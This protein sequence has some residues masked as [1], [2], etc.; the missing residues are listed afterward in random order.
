[1]NKSVMIKFLS[2]LLLHLDNSGWEPLTPVNIGD[3]VKQM[4]VTIC[5][6]RSGPRKKIVGTSIDVPQRVS[7]C[8]VEI[9]D[10]QIIFYTVPATV[11]AD[12]IITSSSDLAGVSSGVVSIISDYITLQLPI[13]S[14]PSVFLQFRPRH[15]TR[16]NSSL[17]S[18]IIG[19]FSNAGYN[20]SIV[21]SLNHNDSVFFFILS[22]S[23]SGEVRQLTRQVAGLGLKDS[24][25]PFQPIV[26]RRKSSF[27]RSFN[28]RASLRKRLERSLKRK[29]GLNVGQVDWYQRNSSNLSTD[30]EDV[31]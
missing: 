5:F 29:F 13:I 23:S 1:M 14:R 18:D 30:W 7:C 26:K 12:I 31:E 11:L 9:T 27:F 3:Q 2:E 15:E 17:K 21:I 8:S 22:R 10:S 24:L 19:C 4:I 6:K 28:D 25:S 16:R 20:L